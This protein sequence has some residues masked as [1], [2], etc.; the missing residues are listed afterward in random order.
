MWFIL[1]LFQSRCR[2][3][4][5]RFSDVAS[6]IYFNFVVNFVEPASQLR[7]EL[8]LPSLRQV[9]RVIWHSPHHPAFFKDSPVPLV[10]GLPC[11]S[12]LINLTLLD[13]RFVSSHC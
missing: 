2:A 6:H 8:S 13:Y 11:S 4:N 10:C 5:T 9:L 1:R 12:K 7:S 3:S